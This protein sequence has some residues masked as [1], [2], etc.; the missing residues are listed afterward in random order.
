[1]ELASTPHPQADVGTRPSLAHPSAPYLS[2][3]SGL[4]IGHVIQAKP[5]RVLSRDCCM[6]GGRKNASY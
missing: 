2:V 5:I 1:M 3:V 6:D 4:S